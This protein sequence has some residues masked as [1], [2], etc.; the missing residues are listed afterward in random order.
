MPNANCCDNAKL[1]KHLLLYLG[2]NFF[3][4]TEEIVG[5]GNVNKGLVNGIGR[6][7]SI[8]SKLTV[9]TIDTVILANVI[10]HPRFSKFYLHIVP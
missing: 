10:S 2:S 6:P 7:V 5:V 8:V 9:N 1:I 4:R 3:I